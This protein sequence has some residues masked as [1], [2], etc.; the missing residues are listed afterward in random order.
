MR[1]KE[2]A[3]LTGSTVRTIRY[4]H[5][6]GLLPVPAQR[7][8]IRD[9][10]LVH[11]ARL[12]RIR[13]LAQAG[14][15]LATIPAMAGDGPGALAD[16]RAA[17]AALDEQLRELQTQRD[18]MDR[19]IAGMERDGRLSPMPAVI[20]QFYDRL[21]DEAADERTRRVI[22]RERDF[23]ELAFYRGDM[24]PEAAVL[25]ERLAGADLAESSE[26]FRQIADRA[27]RAGPIDQQEMER[28]AAMHAERLARWLGEDFLPVVR[29]I[30]I[31]TARRAADLWV[32]LA[33]PP[34]RLLDRAMADAII[35]L[36]EKGQAQ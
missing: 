15:P 36:I 12:V 6:I 32:R 13:W 28:I 14:V 33:A 5:Q 22:R 35:S 25:Y 27:D 34:Q 31:E 18:R 16:L 8:G 11:V 26:G 19:L 2:L 30:D 4:Y 1:I 10:G 21:Y 20:G 7:D 9:Y 17:V 29:S 23:M 24:P 3:D